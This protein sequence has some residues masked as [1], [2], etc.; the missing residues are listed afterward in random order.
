MNFGDAMRLVR[1]GKLVRIKN[2]NY[3]ICKD[4][5]HNVER[6]YKDYGLYN[7]L[8]DHNTKLLCTFRGNDLEVVE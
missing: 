7:L 3:V 6:D 8:N 5:I 2:T 1:Q 4:T